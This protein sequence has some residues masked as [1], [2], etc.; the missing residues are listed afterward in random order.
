MTNDD[1]GIGL[2]T[3]QLKQRAGETAAQVK[4]RA[5]EAAAQAQQQAQQ[6]ISNAW[7]QGNTLLED[8][9]RQAAQRVA[10][11]AEALHSS[12][13]RLDEQDQ[14]LSAHYLHRAAAGLER[15]AQAL[16][17]Q[18]MRALMQ[19]VE[20]FVRRRPGAVLGGAMLGGFLLARFLKSS[21]QRHAEA[22]P[23]TY[24]SIRRRAVSYPDPLAGG[25]G[26]F[27][28]DRVR[29]EVRPHTEAPSQPA[30]VRSADS[31]TGAPDKTQQA[32]GLGGTAP[33]TTRAPDPLTGAPDAL[34]SV[35]TGTSAIAG[36]S[37]IPLVRSADPLTG[38]PDALAET[39]KGER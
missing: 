15:F 19:Q 38:A 35:G 6:M 8:Q 34:E 7:E 3:E 4:Q 1:K 23:A 11:V 33:R 21:A 29:Y 12:A 22:Y 16:S 30:F 32:G 26:A 36:S 28:S 24:P 27:D 5:G 39:S 37:Q 2:Y 14:R 31:L 9:K 17:D 25:P 20:Q 18:D 13:Q 10:G